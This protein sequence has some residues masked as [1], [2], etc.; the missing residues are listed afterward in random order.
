MT[1]GFKRICDAIAA[2]AAGARAMQHDARVY[3]FQR[4]DR[5]E[6][7]MVQ[8]ACAVCHWRSLNEYVQD[9]PRVGSPYR[10]DPQ[11]TEKA[12][13]DAIEHEVAVARFNG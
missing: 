9:A 8:A 5:G 10:T 6:I 4:G 12:E 11:A 13:N 1:G 7:T 3:R 2:D